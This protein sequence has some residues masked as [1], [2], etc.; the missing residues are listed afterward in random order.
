MSLGFQ[1]RSSEAAQ[2][3]ELNKYVHSEIYIK[4]IIKS[5]KL[6]NLQLYINCTEE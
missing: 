6:N 5:G 1:T 4:Y 3:Y 2:F